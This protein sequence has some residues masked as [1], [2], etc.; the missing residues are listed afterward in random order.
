MVKTSY[1]LLLIFSETITRKLRLREGKLL[2]SEEHSKHSLCE[3]QQQH[4]ILCEEQSTNVR[5]QF[6]STVWISMI[7]TGIIQTI[8]GHQPEP[9]YTSVNFRNPLLFFSVFQ[10]TSSINNNNG[11]YLGFVFVL[12]VYTNHIN[13]VRKAPILAFASKTWRGQRNCSRSQNLK[14]AFEIHLIGIKL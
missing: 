11:K 3:K 2:I 7:H 5:K 1:T 6:L 12:Y 4:Q 13:L 10:T 14:V 8:F 9:I